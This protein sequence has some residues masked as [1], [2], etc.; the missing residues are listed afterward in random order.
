MNSFLKKFNLVNKTAIVIGGSGQIGKHTVDVLL[1]AGAVVINLDL[2]NTQKKVKNYHF[3]KIDIS[4]EKN[5]I[6][7]KK[8]FMR[9]FHKLNILINH[10]H[11]KG[12]NRFLKPKSNF[13]KS[14]MQYSSKEWDN[15]IKTNLNGLFYTTKHFLGLLLKNKNSVIVNTSSTYGKVSPNPIIYGKSGIN[16][17]ISY[18]TTKSAIIGFTKYLA[19]HYGGRGL[20]AN[21]L[22]PGGVKNKAQ[23]NNFRKNYSKLTPMK[24]MANENEYKETILFMVSDASSYMNGSEII[25]DG[26]WT[27]W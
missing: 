5:I 14:V 17:P 11:Y 9:K 15:V 2:T 1:D 10:S 12:N 27:A 22:I 16:A 6:S 20:R 24:R 23:T 26:G 19:A 25:V 18:S 3:Y 7:F 21:I 8:K 13:F 4:K